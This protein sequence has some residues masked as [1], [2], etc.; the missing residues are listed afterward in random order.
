M[1][2][3]PMATGNGAYIVHKT[4]EQGIN[5]YSVLPYNPYRTLFSPSLW[6]L[7][8]RLKPSIIHTTPDYACF[9]R[10]KGVPLILTF[11]NY[12]LDTFMRAYSS[13]LQTIHYQTDLKWFTKKAVRFADEV[14]AVS[15][16]TA[17]LVQ[18]ELAISKKIRV[19]YNGVDESSFVPSLNKTRTNGEIKVLFSGNL[20][21]RK[22]AQWLLPILNKL[23]SNVTILYTSGLRGAGELANHPRLVNVGRVAYADMPAL[24]QSA[25]ILLFPT[26]REGFGLAAAEAMACGL[27]VVATNCS[28]LPELIDNGKGGFL[29]ELGNVDEFASRVN[30]LADNETLRKEMGGYNR[31]KVEERFT[32]N[33]M[34]AEYQGLFEKMLSDFTA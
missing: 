13:R 30:L 10:Q 5:D 7:G 1:V 29:C 12:V 2:I 22:G 25:D 24:Y 33:R 18:R 20:S 4:L 17:D 6:P 28:A 27:P 9:H 19:I 23:N 15:Q 31:V 11:H 8:R 14:T 16:Y 21:S 32:L 26:V 3:S 34:I